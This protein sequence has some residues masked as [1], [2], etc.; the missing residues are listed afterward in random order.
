M[1]SCKKLFE[2]KSTWQDD[3]PKEQVRR[4]K[5]YSKIIDLQI[6]KEKEEKERLNT[7]VGKILL[8]GL[9]SNLM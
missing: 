6:K 5:E 4:E 7:K 3:K 2:P 9:L 8:L 1:E